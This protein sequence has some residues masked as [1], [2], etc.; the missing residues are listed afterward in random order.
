MTVRIK[1]GLAA[2]IMSIVLAPAAFSQRVIDEIVARVGNDIILKSEF[3]SEKKVVRDELAQQ[4]LQGAQLEQ[5]FQERS[6]HILRDL[7]DTSLLV[8]QAKEMGIN[9]D[10]EVIRSEERMRQEHNR[11]NPKDLINT[12]ED[13]E[14]AISQQMSLEDFKQRIRTQYM[15]SQVL[16]REVYGRV[17][18][19]T[20]ELRAYY[21]S[22]KKDFDKPEGVHLREISV[23]TQNM[24]P[25]EEA[26]QRK[27]IEEALAALK[28]GD[29]LGEVAQ[30]YSESD[31]AQA[32]GD[33]GFFE[34]GQL[35]ADLEAVVNK[36][37]KGQSSD[38]IKTNYGFM[39]INVQDKHPGGVM[40]FESLQT[41]VYNMMFNDRAVPKIRE[42]LTRLRGTGFVDVREGY[43]DTG[44]P[45]KS[46]N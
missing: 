27:K 38:I 3:E 33:L 15:R 6:K 7:I 42:Y 30:K 22:H 36:L 24:K 5:A 4:G 23:N 11:T 13:L 41:D 31:N 46:Q 40:P 20:E 43:T 21:E 37:N 18:I 45:P 14:R 44:A 17:I 19:T 35:A 28:K 29:D 26:V 9:A 34:K 1:A 32:G 10:L 16:N 8:Q 25:E 39:I 12:I 2:I